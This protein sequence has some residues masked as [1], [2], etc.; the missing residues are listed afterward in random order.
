MHNLPFKKDEEKMDLVITHK[1]NNMGHMK[2]IYS[3]IQDGTI[4]V[5][6]LLYNNA[7]KYKLE[8]FIF[9]SRVHSISYAQ[10]VLA[11]AVKAEQEYDKYI[12]ACA[13]AE[14]DAQF[15]EQ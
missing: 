13:D 6:R 2:W 12:D 10:G 11:I 15:L 4:D 8:E 5:Y 7:V 14:Y 1:T 3:M 9:E